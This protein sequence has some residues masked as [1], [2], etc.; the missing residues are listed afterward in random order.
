[1]GTDREPSFLSFL[2]FCSVILYPAMGFVTILKKAWQEELIHWRIDE[3]YFLFHAFYKALQMREKE[4]Q[5]DMYP[6]S[7][8]DLSLGLGSQVC[9][10]PH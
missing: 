3:Y 9:L 8:E 1:M 10:P 5:E 6:G 4:R 2:V 7:G